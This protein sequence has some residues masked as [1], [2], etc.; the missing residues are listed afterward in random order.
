VAID[1]I[2][3]EPTDG[4]PVNETVSDVHVPMMRPSSERWVLPA[5][6]SMVMAGGL[7]QAYANSTIDGLF[8][9]WILLLVGTLAIKTILPRGTQELRVFGLSFGVCILAGGLAQFYSLVS[10]GD[11]MSTV[12]ANKFFSMIYDR[13]PYDTLEDL[14]TVWTGDRFLG[15]GAPLAIVIWQQVYHLFSALGFSHAPY[16][17]VQFNALVVALSGSVTVLTARALFGDDRWRL[18]R[19]GNLYACCGLFV[20]FGAILIRDGFTLFLNLLVFWSLIHWLQR[21]TIRNYVL[22]LVVTI[23]AGV[24]VWYLRKNSTYLFGLFHMLA[25]FCWYWRGR[26]SLG[27]VLTTIALPI[28]LSFASAFVYQYFSASLDA[29][30]TESE[31]YVELAAKE[32]QDD[33]L[34]MSLVVNQP[35]PVRAA[36]GSGVLLAFPIPLWA[37]L[38]SGATEYELIKTWQGAYMLFLLPLALAGFAQV[39]RSLRHRD[40]FA[41][42]QVFIALYAASML[43]AVAATSLETR[44]IGQFLPAFLLLAVMPDTRKPRDQQR[45]RSMVYTWVAVLGGVHFLWAGMRFL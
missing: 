18:R 27:H 36:L 21:P 4:G 2:A 29:L 15:F 7:L 5:V 12:D 22:A 38:K 41:S 25:F 14:A 30:A 45:V 10:F 44:H 17:G 34:G 13:P 26:K 37:Y 33:S 28:I 23:F 3:K 43:A 8:V 11:V 19:V 9:A 40:A 1:G 35:L 24:S 39:I 6:M 16:L 31:N 20:L 32:S 42:E